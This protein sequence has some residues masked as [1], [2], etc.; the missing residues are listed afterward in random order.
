MEEL[1]KILY[2]RIPYYSTLGLKLQEIG[3]GKASFTLSLR[4]ELM[5]NGMVHG[6]VLASLIDSSCACAAIS[7]TYPDGYITTID[8][9]VEFLKPVSKG[10]LLSRAKCIKSGKNIYFCK[11]K[12][13]NSDSELICTGSS[14]LLRIS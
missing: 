11:A 10:R 7:L 3:N 2:K 14:Q 8:L 5:Q 13:W 4:E 9:Q 1:K 6:G 12:V